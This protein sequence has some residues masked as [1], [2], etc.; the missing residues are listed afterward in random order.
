MIPFQVT[1]RYTYIYRLVKQIISWVSCT[2]PFPI[3]Y[4]LNSE[5]R[6]KIYS[7]LLQTE[8]WQLVVIGNILVVSKRSSTLLEQERFESGSLYMVQ[9]MADSFL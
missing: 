9:F 8:T 4:F 6:I 2:G 5:Q 1:D 7:P 3:S